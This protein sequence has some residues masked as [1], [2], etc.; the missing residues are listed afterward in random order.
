MSLFKKGDILFVLF[1]FEERGEEKMRPALFWRHRGQK[2][3]WLLMSKITSRCHGSKWE[4][5]VF[6][7]QTNGLTN[8]SYIQ[9]DKTRKIHFSKVRNKM[10]PIGRLDGALLS[11]AEQKMRD[12]IASAK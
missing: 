3:E 1:P 7:S 11:L 8:I 12:Y 6:P 10:V 4:I 5:K 9:I 2:N